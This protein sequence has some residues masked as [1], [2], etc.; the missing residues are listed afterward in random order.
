MARPTRDEVDRAVTYLLRNLDPEKW[1]HAESWPT[2]IPAEAREAMLTVARI[3]GA[4]REERNAAYRVRR[5]TEDRLASATDAYDQWRNKAL[6]LEADLKV[7]ESKLD[8]IRDLA[9]NTSDAGTF[10]DPVV[11]R[12]DLEDILKEDQ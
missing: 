6:A 4:L 9:E 10:G 1:Q 7:A 8:D 3:V 5:D 2:R 11:L 12:Y